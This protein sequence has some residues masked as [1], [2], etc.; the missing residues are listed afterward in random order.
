MTKSTIKIVLFLSIICVGSQSN[1]ESWSPA[2]SSSYSWPNAYRYCAELA[3]TTRKEWRLPTALE[4]NSRFKNNM[5]KA[6]W[7][8]NGSSIDW[9]WSS[10]KKD[11]EGHY[12]VN[13][14]NGSRS[15]PDDARKAYVLCIS[16]SNLDPS[17]WFDEAVSAMMMKDWAQVIK[18]TA[19]EAKKSN[20]MALVML[21]KLYFDGTGVQK[22]EKRA[23]GLYMNAAQQGYS[24]AQVSVAALYQL[25]VGTPKN[26]NMA[27]YWYDKAAA[28][29][30][31]G[32][33]DAAQRLKTISR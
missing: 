9:L 14:N 7:D 12:L 27:L 30:E 6:P 21:G 20:P 1:A 24:I 29:G 11:G 19:V 16:D 10:T 32:A 15:W 31:P 33:A 17:A 2:A 5:L 3:A 4:L 8:T 18:A 25:G 13:A 23:F 22:D 28:Q 26:L